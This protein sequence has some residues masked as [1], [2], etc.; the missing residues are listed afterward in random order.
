MWDVQKRGV[1]LSFLPVSWGPE[2]VKS[3]CCEHLRP[4]GEGGR[5]NRSPCTSDLRKQTRAGRG[6]I[7]IQPM[8]PGIP[9]EARVPAQGPGHG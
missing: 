6:F 1:H 9:S 2:P 4:T 7:S 8:S 3:H 5:W